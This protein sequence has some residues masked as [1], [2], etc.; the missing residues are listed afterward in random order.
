MATTCPLVVDVPPVLAPSD[1]SAMSWALVLL[2][3][4]AAAA[5]ARVLLKPSRSMAG[6]F[7]TA[8]SKH[9]TP[10]I[11]CMIRNVTFVAPSTNSAV[12]RRWQAA[13]VPTGYRR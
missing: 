13:A 1:R 5:S 4:V 3:P 11:L 9:S 8:N 6:Y 7:C 12:A 10:P 2:W